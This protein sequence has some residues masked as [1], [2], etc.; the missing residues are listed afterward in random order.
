MI[1]RR[2]YIVFGSIW[3]VALVLCYFYLPT[4]GVM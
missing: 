3:A 2:G 1:T 4:Y